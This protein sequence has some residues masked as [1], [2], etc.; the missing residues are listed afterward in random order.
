M[1]RYALQYL[2]NWKNNK[3]H[4]PLLVYG[5]R[6][7][8][9]TWLMEEFGKTCFSDY[10]LVNLEINER[11]ANVFCKTMDPRE[12]LAALE[13]EMHKKITPDTLIILDEIQA[14]PKAITS[15]KYFCE[16]MPE[17][18]VIAAG[19]L[20]GVAIH[21]GVS[22]PVGKVES[23]Y[24]YPMTFC[25][26]LDAIGEDRICETINSRNFTLIEM[27]KD[28][29]IDY[30]KLYFYIGGMP[31]VVK[32]YVEQKD[33]QLVRTIQN[34]I[35]NDYK[36]DFSNHIPKEIYTQ[37][38]MLWESI[39]RQLAKENKKF[40]YKEVSGD[41]AR[42]KKYDPAIQW[43]KDSGLIYQIYRLSKPA[44]PIEAY[45]EY[46]VFKLFMSDIGLLSAKS[47]LDIRVLLEGSKVFTEFKGAIT[48]QYVLQEIKAK[49]DINVAY[50][51]NENGQAEI[52]FVVQVGSKIMPVEVKAGINLKAQSLNAYRNK[53]NPDCSVRTSLA[54]YKVS[55]N[56]YDIPLYMIE[57]ID[58]ICE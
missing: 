46:N 5:A 4:K 39:P 44:M 11:I 8:G 1:K 30:L 31:E 52:D 20:L 14:C 51:A 27:F 18:Y 13:M 33:F 47:N 3:N 49:Q 34:R 12:I 40:V 50:W 22:F 45:K 15:L 29:I 57:L 58:K 10:C 53:F 25:E 36:E 23:L 56:L 38:T 21:N 35:L 2:I 26:F 41:N 9:K 28:K 6:Q 32:N 24:L 42:A 19:S 7:V 37:V 43:L 17:Y 54:D 16:I 55:D 48:E